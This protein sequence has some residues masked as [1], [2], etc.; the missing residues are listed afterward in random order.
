[1]YVQYLGKLYLFAGKYLAMAL[2]RNE[3]APEDANIA[4]FLQVAFVNLHQPNTLVLLGKSECAFS[5]SGY[6]F[7]RRNT[8]SSA[9]S[10]WT[11]KST[12]LTSSS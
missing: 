1:M 2:T 12:C 3:V 9:P 4:K 10:A 7:Q 8:L 11:T 5:I 6:N